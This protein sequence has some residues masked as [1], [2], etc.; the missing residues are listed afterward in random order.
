M[1]YLIK[2]LMADYYTIMLLRIL[3][4]K[5][6]LEYRIYYYDLQVYSHLFNSF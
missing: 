3:D 4:I 1:I 6:R 5:L 2:V